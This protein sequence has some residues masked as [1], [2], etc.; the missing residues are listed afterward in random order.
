MPPTNPLDGRLAEFK[1]IVDNALRQGTPTLLLTPVSLLEELYRRA[2]ERQALAASCKEMAKL[3][4]YVPDLTDIIRPDKIRERAEAA[5]ALCESAGAEADGVDLKK[6]EE[7]S[8]PPSPAEPYR[9]PSC[10]RPFHRPCMCE[11][12][13][14]MVRPVEELARPENWGLGD[15]IT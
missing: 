12:C 3:M 8:R 5:L 7:E 11:L 13:R 1:T 4:E 10:G 2:D 6:L 15:E 14:V 9:C